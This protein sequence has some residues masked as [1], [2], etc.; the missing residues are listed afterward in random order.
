M[1]PRWL[2]VK[3]SI[4]TNLQKKRGLWTSRRKLTFFSS[5]LGLEEIINYCF[6][7]EIILCSLTI[8]AK[9]GG[10]TDCTCIAWQGWQ[11][12]ISTG[13]GKAWKVAREMQVCWGRGV[14]ASS[15]RKFWDVET[16]KWYFQ[17]PQWHISLKKLNLD[18]VLNK[19]I[20][21]LE[22]LIALPYQPPR[23]CRH[24][25]GMDNREW[26]ILRGTQRLFSVKHLFGEA[27]IAQNFLLLEDG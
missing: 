1:K 23:L 10:Q 8:Y 16:R 22:K 13:W 6:W 24:C 12:T 2:P 5:L 14:G 9:F 25:M 27:Y 26:H 20:F 17:H 11:S 21:P 4:L 15:P 18:K 19:N 7:M 3:S